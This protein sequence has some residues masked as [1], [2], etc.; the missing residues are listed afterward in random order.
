MELSSQF[1]QKTADFYTAWKWNRSFHPT[2]PKISLEFDRITLD[3]FF[4]TLASHEPKSYLQQGM[5]KLAATLKD[6]HKVAGQIKQAIC[7]ERI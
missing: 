4:E 1:G 2:K 3:G 6:Q 5:E 7:K